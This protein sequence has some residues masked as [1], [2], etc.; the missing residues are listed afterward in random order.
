MLGCQYV[1]VDHVVHIGEVNKVLAITDCTDE[2][3][4]NSVKV[5]LV[6][7]SVRACMSGGCDNGKVDDECY[8]I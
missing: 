8:K 1:S 7:Y 3:G 5:F 6:P 2:G 4:R